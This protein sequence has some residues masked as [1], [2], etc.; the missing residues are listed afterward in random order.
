MLSEWNQQNG[1]LSERATDKGLF[2]KFVFEALNRSEDL[3]LAP[4]LDEA[5]ETKVESDRVRA[6]YGR[7][8]VHCMSTTHNM[9]RDF[10]R[11][12][13]Q[14]KECGGPVD[15]SFLTDEHLDA[16]IAE[17]NF[18]AHAHGR[19]VGDH[20]SCESMFDEEMTSAVMRK[21]FDTLVSPFKLG[22]CC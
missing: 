14:Y 21:E 7:G 10:V 18:N 2:R 6:R 5:M 8:H 12:A 11:C 20:A 9:K 16:A 15:T 22:G 17:A 4:T 1:F 19:S 13:H 3:S